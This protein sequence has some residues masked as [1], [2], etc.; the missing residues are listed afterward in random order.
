MGFIHHAQ[1]AKA[2]RPIGAVFSIDEAVQ[3]L[4]Q[5]VEDKVDDNRAAV[6]RHVRRKLDDPALLEELCWA[7]SRLEERKSANFL[8]RGDC[9]IFFHLVFC[10]NANQCVSDMPQLTRA[11]AAQC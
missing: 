2:S 9:A 11:L 6:L 10:I 8:H 1:D 5:R 7:E 4:V 3:I